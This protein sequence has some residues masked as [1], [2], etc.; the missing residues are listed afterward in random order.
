MKQWMMWVAGAVLAVASLG[1]CSGCSTAEVE[2]NAAR[3]THAVIAPAYQHYVE[4]DESLGAAQLEIERQVLE[5]WERAVELEDRS[6]ERAVHA[7]VAPRFIGYV[8]ADPKLDDDQK[9]RRQRHV[10]AWGMR[11]EEAR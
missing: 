1:A 2:D 7:H 5:R 10:K 4:A 8:E 11:L 9:A 3:S 6:S